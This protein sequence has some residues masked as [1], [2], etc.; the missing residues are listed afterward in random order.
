M[1]H[2]DPTRRE[3][4]DTLV[5]CSLGLSALAAL[6]PAV[7]FVIPPEEAE[8]AAS[9]VLP[10]LAEDM[11]PDSGR[12]FQF[13]SQP[14]LVIKTSTGEVRAFSAKCTHLSCIVEYHQESSRILCNCHAGWYDLKG[15]NVAG[16][17]PSPLEAYAVNLRRRQE[18]DG[19][20]IVVSRA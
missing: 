20:E 15:K 18:N 6:Y 3:F 17:P 1:V 9:V 19:H 2:D 4:V 5:G 14:G 12:V 10:F 7:A 16:P 13:G 11:P 8:A